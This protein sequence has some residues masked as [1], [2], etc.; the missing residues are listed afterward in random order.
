M[1]AELELVTDS[2]TQHWVFPASFAQQRLWFLEQLEGAG[3]VWNVRLPVR[4]TGTLDIAALEQA[5]AAVVARH[6]ALRTTLQMRGGDIL[7]VVASALTVPVERVAL[8]EAT[9]DE[10]RTRLGELCSG[11]FDLREGPLLRVFLVELAPADHVLLILSHHCV[12][13]AWSSGVLFRD[14][15]ASYTALT[16]GRPPLLPA[17]PIQYADFAVWQRDWLAGPELE[18]QAAYWREHLKNAPVLLD[19]PVDR[20][21]P[22]LQSYRGHRLGHG[23]PA[24][25][26]A[27]LKSLAVTEGVTLFMLLFAAFNV[28]LAR[29]SGQGDLV[30]GTPIA[31]RRR[32]ELEGLVGF[33]A[34]T[35][36]LRTRVD[37]AVNFR[38]LL[39]QVRATA[40]A[41][42][43]HQDLPFEKLVEVLQPPRSLAH[44]PVFQVL[45]VL[46][47]APW[48]AAGF[49]ALQVAPAES[50]PAATAR[51]DLTVSAS[52]FEGQLWL[53]LEYSTDLFDART[54]A[55]L[56][57]GFEA[58]LT[59]IVAAPGSPLAT[60]PVQAEADRRRQLQEWQPALTQLS[61]PESV[62]GLFRDQ[63]ARSPDATAV[64][65]GDTRLSYAALEARAGEVAA[66]LLAAGMDPAVPV[67]LCLERS[68]DMLAA[69]L[70]VL[71]AGGHY[72]PLD[73]HHP[74]AR[75]ASLLQDSGAVLLVSTPEDAGQSPAISHVGAASA[76]MPL[77]F[78]PVGASTTAVDAP[79]YLIYTSG[80]TGRPKGV[81]VGQR[82]VVKFLNSMATVPGLHPGDR[83]LAVTTLA[84]DIAVLEL[85]LPLTVGATT[86]IAT[87]EDLRDPQQ[88]LALLVTAGIT[89]MQAT[90]AL[91]RNLL[92]A[93][94][95]GTPGLRLLCGGEAL[96]RELATALLGAGAELWNLYG[97]TETTVWSC[98]ERVRAEAGPVSIGRPIG[99]TRCY[100]L[101]EE[102][103]PV[104]IG[105]HGELWI[106]GDGVAL[107]Y[108]GQPALTAERFRAD[109][110][111][112][113]EQG[114]GRMYGTGDRARWRADGRLEVLGRQDFQVKLR[115][116]RIEPVEIEAALLARPGVSAAVVVLREVA[117]DP[118][119]VAF[120]VARDV[121]VPDAVLLA[122]LRESLPGY[123][124]PSHLLWL[125]ALPLTPN[126]KLDRGALPP[127][128]APLGTNGARIAP[129]GAP[130][131]ALETALS[132]LFSELL[133][134]PV[135]LD[136]DF[137]ARGGHSLLATRLVA[138]IRGDLQADVSL[139]SLFE[140]PT[141]RGLA[142]VVQ[143]STRVGVA[144]AAT[145]P[146]VEGSRLKPLLPIATAP[147]SLVQQRLWFLDRLA[148]GNSAYHLAWAFEVRGLLDRPALQRVLDELAARHGSLRTHFRDQ[149]GEPLQVIGA[150]RGWP[151][152]IVAGASDLP[153]QL[154]AEAA[155]PLQLSRGPLIRAVLIEQ[156]PEVHTLLI[157]IHHILA[158]GWSFGV[159]SRELALH[160]AAACRGEPVLL[161]D[162]A[163][164]YAGYAR[165]Q[166]RSLAGGELA[167]QLAYWQTQLRDLQPCIDL[168][169]DRPRP[170]VASGKGARLAR[171]LPPALQSAV[172]TRARAE[173]CT[174]F[175]V[176]LTAFDLL[177]AR[178][179]GTEDVVVG[180][181]IA[182]RPRTE[183]EGLVGFFV[184]T[185]VLRTSLSGNP[186]VRELLGRVR[187]M[188]LAAFEHA[189]VPFELLVETLQ[190]PRSTS[191]T[192]LFQVLFN[193]HSEPHSPLGLEGLEVRPL[194]IPRHTAKFELS[195]SLAETTAG[196]AVSIEYSTDLF[197]PASMARLLDDYAALLGAL[198]AAP[199]ARLTELPFSPREPA[200]P[201]DLV[202]L[203]TELTL[204]AA[205]A[206][207]VAQR[208]DALAVSAPATGGCLAIDWTYAQLDRE[209]RA[210]AAAL[211]G[212]GLQPGERVGLWFA[213]GAGQVAGMLGVLQAGGVYV[214]LD[215]LA[216]AA[217]L[218]SVSRDA[219]LRVLVTDRS[220][221]V[222]PPA[223]LLALAREELLASAEL[224]SFPTVEPDSL[225]Y[226][227]YTSG[228]TGTPKGVPQTH[229]N[230][231]HFIR[232]WAGNLG[233][234]P[235]DRL[236]LFSTSGYDAA[237][238]DIFGALLTG[239]AVCP[240]DV[241]GLDR[242]TLLDRVA[243]RGLT[244]LHGTP[245]VYRY[246]FGGRVAC[247]QD[248]S[249]VGLVVLGGEVARRADFE[250]FCA[251]F[252][253]GA[254]FV[255]GYGLTE[256]TAVTQWFAGHATRPYGQQLPIGRPVGGLALELVD[257][258]GAPAALVGELVI[259]SSHV[260]PGYWPSLTRP[261]RFHTGD[262]AR[263]LPDGTLVFVGRVDER[264]KIAGIR[265]EPGDIEA[266]LRSLPAIRE[267]VV[268]APPDPSGEP[269][270]VAYCIFVA[271][272]PAP[273]VRLLRARLATLLPAALIPARCIPC[274][275]FPRLP[276]GKVDRHAL[277]GSGRAWSA[278]GS[279]FEERLRDDGEDPVADQ[280]AP[281]DHIH[282]TLQ[283]LWE[284]LL[285]RESVGLDEDFFLLGGHSLLATRLVARIRDRLGVEV[286]L[287]RVFEAPTIR[288][289]AR[290]L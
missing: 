6:E 63:V 102:Q 187:A 245:T 265:I 34:N 144:L 244:V 271:G 53:G 264:L 256:A 36:A 39:L 129:E 174:V 288:G 216:P 279:S 197:L 37:E 250:L 161:P 150:A 119:L 115:G 111:R 9:E 27:Q 127:V 261:R 49:G 190:P 223:G 257:E 248:L 253:P 249:R 229:R 67:A 243:D 112:A 130:T 16:R 238:Q 153:A 165:E 200:T 141:V 214:P 1:N 133:G 191:R 2:G 139:R 21:R 272:E 131:T 228:S 268:L 106:G 149:D 43:T 98:C 114:G 203:A 236:S 44:S 76:A 195:V 177:L 70:G 258:A 196:L 239:A 237:V 273:T 77:V 276:N 80:S 50:A 86:V 68:V 240:L 151:L 125:A 270:L 182:G 124:V 85:L 22:R 242:E 48:D 11:T 4:L 211:I 109:P 189:E 207:Q 72:L 266:A 12:S 290:F 283:D 278:T 180:T 93:G 143:G 227:L 194:P 247:R 134:A 241:R 30:I 97:P 29:W 221:P 287:I 164:D 280:A 147:V 87:E 140:T 65:C 167:R 38:E 232:A 42:F 88:L 101:D 18:R 64:E 277:A 185:L 92:A 8:P 262:R 56:A 179:A 20:P 132:A 73:P 208:P 33:F 107:G 116:F 142:A 160:Y 259:E 24:E 284:R 82:A 3:P 209:A 60:L 61:G 230:V 113:A 19:L 45:F 79:A 173:G 122:A 181:P 40:L 75:R 135:G 66:R 222:P 252:R 206:A 254:R 110:F 54:I 267:A 235:E 170:A 213:Q 105:A 146:Q 159:L 94:W 57:S 84:F 172:T 25:L 71:R 81:L 78:A 117:G 59:G 269:V 226:L 155:A 62:Y 154:A 137:F 145:S 136:D 166:R 46:Q 104:P 224:P 10:L 23:L 138:R 233:L 184:N 157:V 91:W 198:V 121:P 47:N 41:A 231:L 120:L 178:Y 220:A 162:L 32:T 210:I 218:A 199:E 128:G 69:V 234:T 215:P 158:D 148:P 103:Q 289:L 7:Q 156:T 281:A 74:P 225:A 251:R 193:L 171:T 188:T 123:M 168:P 99:N 5:V 255:N 163:M 100:V 108:H 246:L 176:L 83:L 89:V 275:E 175:V 169:T 286:P 14:L 96:D 15:A 26:T 31:G 282:A 28:L 55:R 205:F 202:P 95:P 201:R 263:Y 192:P 13:D 260:T 212:H 217:R 285:Q 58:L 186:T 17:L 52:E 35:L 126:G 51:F 90:P 219:G 274:Q 118:R 183:L 152:E 204:P